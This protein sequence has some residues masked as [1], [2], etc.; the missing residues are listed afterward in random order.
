MQATDRFFEVFCVDQ[1][2]KDFDLTYE[3]ILTGI[4]DGPSDGGIDWAYLLVNG[5]IVNIDDDIVLPDK[6][7]L[8]LLLAIG[9]SKN[10]DTFKET[11]IDRLK[12]RLEV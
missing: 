10:E 7:D 4:F 3:D 5:T 8:E 2:M 11:P 9:Q 1:I 12:S 6:G